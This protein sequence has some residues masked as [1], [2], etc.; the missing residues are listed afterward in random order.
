MIAAVNLHESLHITF[1]TATTTMSKQSIVE[2]TKK[3]EEGKNLKRI[4][5]KIIQ[6]KNRKK[7]ITYSYTCLTTSM[8]VSKL[9]YSGSNSNKMTT[10]WMQCSG[11][12]TTTFGLKLIVG[13]IFKWDFDM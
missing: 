13:N 12:L 5:K 3:M 1:T 10:C 4:K 2:Q 9:C 6:K 11:K 7:E 8:A